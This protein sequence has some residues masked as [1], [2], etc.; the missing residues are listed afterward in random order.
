[1]NVKEWAEKLNGREYRDEMTAKEEN[2][3]KNDGVVI[4]FGASDDLI[5]FR[6]AI[7]HED[8]AW[9]G[10]E[11][12]ITQDLT[13]FSEDSNKETFKYNLEQIIKMP[14]VKATWCPKELETSWL[15]ST[16]IPH[17]TFD[18]ME[19]DE[20]YCRG[21]VFDV[22]HLKQEEPHADR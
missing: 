22:K 1:M 13:I 18:I 15:V 17:E 11:C 16:A 3:A 21:I 2:D 19:D 12:R 5:E 10:T 20:L 9:E 6:G 4:V 7:D 8:G 14:M